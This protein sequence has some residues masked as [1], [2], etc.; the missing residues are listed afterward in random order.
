MLGLSLLILLVWLT[1]LVRTILNLRLIRRLRP[2]PA[3]GGGE[4]VSVIIPARDE[5]RIIG[6]TV[7]A[8]LAQ[9][10]PN[11]EVIVVD[12]R[13]TD[14]TGE[15]LRSIDDPRLTV[16]HGEEPP[17]GWLGKP[18]ALH[19]GSR[20]ARGSLL[21][22]VDA[23]VI[24]E[25]PAIAAAVAEMTAHPDLG[26][27][28]LLPFF[29]MRGFWENLA[30]PQLGLVAFALLPTWYSNRSRHAGLAMGGGCGN[31]VR[32]EAYDEAG[33]HESLADAVVDDVGLARLLRQHGRRTEAIRADD[34]VHLRMYEG[35]RA[36]IEGFTKNL[37]A[38]CGRNYVL[39]ILFLLMS[40][41]LSF[42]PFFLIAAHP[43]LNA[44]SLAVIVLLRVILYRSLRYRLDSAIFG[45]QLMTL[46]WSW[47]VLR[48][49]W[50]T[51]IKR[52]VL[53]RGR[54]YDA[55]RTRFGGKR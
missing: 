24:Y 13:S 20:R 8:M 6:R 36:I 17:P 50:K 23:D 38:V 22:F 5:A 39:A 45:Q 42:G 15:I 25:P 16:I 34:L 43:Y 14:G 2:V 51:G 35:A 21:L 37:F 53:W 4:L 1:S 28:A 47:I 29:E 19:Q 26:L 44:A 55:A 10:Y 7:R 54:T 12:D 3:T 27:L 32:R 52:E 48:S 18:W 31:L 33:G 41:L 30:M 9:T 40:L 46:F 11:L 49:V